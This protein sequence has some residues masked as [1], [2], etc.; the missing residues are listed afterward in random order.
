D[1]LVRLTTEDPLPPSQ[2]RLD[3]DRRLEAACLKA[4]ARLPEKRFTNMAELAQALDAY[5]A[6]APPEVSARGPTATDPNPVQMQQ[7][8]LP[9]PVFPASTPA[10][11]P[12]LVSPEITRSDTEIA[13]FQPPVTPRRGW[14]ILVG[15]LL[16]VGIIGAGG[17]WMLNRPAVPQPTGVAVVP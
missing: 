3:L 13:K 10:P 15:M 9:V 5:L 17:Y 7:D 16:A 12:N 4:M 6:D 2:S 8:S 11:S 1:V 14:K